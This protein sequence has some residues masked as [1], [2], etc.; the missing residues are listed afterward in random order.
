MLVWR[1]GGTDHFWVPFRGHKVHGD[2]EMLPDFVD[3]Y[4]RADVVFA[5][6]VGEYARLVPHDGDASPGNKPYVKIHTPVFKKPASGVERVRVHAAAGYVPD[7]NRT[8]SRRVAATA[9]TVT[10]GGTQH[11]ATRD[12]DP[13]FW[14]ADVDT[15]LVADGR[16]PLSVT[17]TYEGTASQE[18]P[19]T[20][21]H[22]ARDSHD[23][24]IVNRRAPVTAD[25]YLID[26]FESYDSTDDNRTDLERVWRR[27]GDTMI[28]LRLRSS[29]N[30][31]GSWLSNTWNNGMDTGT[32]LRVKYDAVRNSFAQIT[33]RMDQVDWSAARS[34]G[35]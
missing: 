3:Y 14:A 28:G 10:L 35:L 15:A 32:V 9:V 24:L 33:R 30:A 13:L 34:L 31:P 8:T 1:N 23:I 4:H 12:A 6:G 26:D 21:T 17:A 19:A 25:P 27:D 5:G 22:E 11:A 2:H 18:A 7:D 16:H 29:G 20:A